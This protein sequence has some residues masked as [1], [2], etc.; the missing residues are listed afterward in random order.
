MPGVFGVSAFDGRVVVVAGACHPLGRSLVRRLAGYGADVIAIDCDAE[1][2]R[3]LAQLDPVH[4]EALSLPLDDPDA[5]AI[6]METWAHEPLFAM[7]DLSPLA[8]DPG[9]NL[10]APIAAVSGLADALCAG[11]AAGRGR[12][13]LALPDAQQAPDFARASA[14]FGA[15]VPE[16]DAML[17]PARL[18]GVRLKT[19][20]RDWTEQQLTSSGDLVLALC[21]PVSRALVGGHVLGV[22][23]G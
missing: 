2:L 5:R 13:I 7:F 14:A 19:G 1:A 12:A 18:H 6:L 23:A 10:G 15:M 17:H 8:C 22:G 21:H 20:T 3:S 11:L 4:I 9:Q 16:L